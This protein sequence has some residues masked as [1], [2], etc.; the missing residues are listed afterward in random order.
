MSTA[1]YY[2]S[3]EDTTA[4]AVS[5]TPH[6][7]APAGIIVDSAQEFIETTSTPPLWGQNLKGLLERRLAQQFPDSHYRIAL[8][9]ERRSGG[10]LPARRWVLLGL[11]DEPPLEAAVAA[12]AQTQI[13]LRGLWTSTQLIVAWLQAA[14]LPASP[15]LVVLTTP[16]G[17]RLV[18]W[19]QIALVTRLLPSQTSISDLVSEIER[20]VTYL[21][22]QSLVPR[23]ET[24]PVIAGGL[25]ELPTNG[26][27]WHQTPLPPRA[28]KLAPALNQHGWI[29]LLPWWQRQYTY[30]PS[31]LPARW[32]IA[33]QRRQLR[34]ALLAGSLML[35]AT[36]LAWAGTL[37][38]EGKQTLDSTQTT[39]TQLDTT[40]R[41]RDSTVSQIEALGQN[42]PA[43][44]AALDS[45]EAL[46]AS[47]PWLTD[48]LNALSQALMAAPEYHLEHLHWQAATPKTSTT[49]SSRS[50]PNTPSTQPCLPT[51]SNA[52][53]SFSAA[54]VE[55][56][57]VIDEN[58]PA[59][60]VLAV[61]ERFL[62]SLQ[63]HPWLHIVWDQPPLRMSPDTAIKGDAQRLE[64]G[65]MS[66]CLRLERSEPQ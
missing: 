19:Q 56:S 29:A 44:L 26:T 23:G 54:W 62:A 57:A 43:L 3:D 34:L 17:I 53:S 2:L 36:L 38:F 6:P 14:K 41:L 42:V 39:T 46:F 8:P 4:R 65:S 16:A 22:N 59:R 58:L 24:V 21:Y 10:L 18:F 45:F 1:L 31:L 63:A 60:H 9:A 25:A 47:R 30:P 61:H 35:N 51:N 33:F 27:G 49:P 40:Q 13:P 20:T 28:H 66:I 12:L 64:I 11:A 32:R 50:T 5:K 37:A 48:A 15:H 55:L 52:N 7:N